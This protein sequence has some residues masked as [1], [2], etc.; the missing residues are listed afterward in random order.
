MN[1]RIT[2]APVRFSLVIRVTESSVFCTFLY[3]GTVHFIITETTIL[4]RTITSKKI[5]LIFA[6]MVNAI[7]NAPATING[8]RKNR[9]S[10]ILTELC[11]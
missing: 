6:S 5:R 1:A 11:A 3:I 4:R 2:L 7:I 8:E 9:R 10:T